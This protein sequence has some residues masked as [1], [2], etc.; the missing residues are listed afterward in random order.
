[1]LKIWFN[2]QIEEK[3]T[4]LF[5]DALVFNIFDKN[6]KSNVKTDVEILWRKFGKK[7]LKSIY[8]D[9]LIIAM[10]IFCA[11]KKIPRRYFIDNWTRI[12]KLNI[13]VIELEKWNG[14]KEDLERSLN[15]LSG[16]KWNIEFRKSQTKFRGEKI[17][18]NNL[19]RDIDFDGVSLFSGGLDSFCGAIKL[20]EEGKKICFVGFKEYGALRGRQNELFQ[21]INKFYESIHKEII[22]FNQNPWMPLNITDE[23]KKYG[24]ENTSRSRSFLFIAGAMAVASIIGSDIPVYIPENGFIGINVPLTDSR[25][26]SCSTR[27][28][29]PYFINSLNQMLEGVGINNKIINFYAHMSKGRIVSELENNGV[30]KTYAGRTISCSHPCQSRYDKIKPPKNCGY[31]YPCLI[32]R[33]AMNKINYDEST[34]YNYNNKLSKNFIEMYNKIDGKSSDLKA[35][36]LSIKNYLVNKNDKNY[37]NYILLKHGSLKYEEIDK[38]KEVYT[39][40]MDELLAMIVSE[41]IKNDG[42]LREY[43]GIEEG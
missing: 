33:A 9:L 20:L 27:T 6:D 24:G 38:Y 25:N 8:E 41:D 18:K 14:V 16:D 1:M 32:R 43:L 37:L 15:F 39:D 30:F 2:K 42:Q 13:P 22:L 23:I 36:L 10:S 7:S 19:I 5:E 12:I 35:V 31:C 40:S 4:D 11:D 26:G 21:A 34:V 3:P 29:H 17:N 28:T